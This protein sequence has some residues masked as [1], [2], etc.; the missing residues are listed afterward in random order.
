MLTQLEQVA[1][2]FVLSLARKIDMYVTFTMKVEVIG[3][4]SEKLWWNNLQ[5]AV[6]SIWD[7]SENVRAA[8]ISPTDLSVLDSDTTVQNLC[9]K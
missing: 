2:P 8:D 7:C 6:T 4:I 1:V 5:F 9:S 3:E